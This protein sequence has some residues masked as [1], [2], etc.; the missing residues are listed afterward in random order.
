MTI[1]DEDRDVTQSHNLNPFPEPRTIPT[2]WDMSA[3]LSAAEVDSVTNEVDSTDSE[4][5]A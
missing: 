2:G 4:S 3:L 1:Q 5:K